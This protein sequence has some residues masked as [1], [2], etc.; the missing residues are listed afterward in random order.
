MS[1]PTLLC[2]QRVAADGSGLPH[3]REHARNGAHK[4]SATLL[5]A[6]MET[7]RFHRVT[8]QYPK[9]S[10]AS[11]LQGSRNIGGQILS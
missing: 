5:F 4:V 3:V 11:M 6:W 2:V 10:C 8:I 1:L 9:L 7:G